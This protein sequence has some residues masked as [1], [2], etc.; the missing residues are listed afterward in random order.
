M[1]IN[2][3][4]TNL[5]LTCGFLLLLSCTSVNRLPDT[6]DVEIEPAS[7]PEPVFQ[8]EDL[9]ELFS[10]DED[11]NPKKR[12]F[13]ELIYPLVEAVNR[14]VLKERSEILAL[15]E[16]SRKKFDVADRT[17]LILWADKYRVVMSGRTHQ[18]VIEQLLLQ[19]DMVAPSLAIAQ[20]ANESGWGTSRF[21]IEANNYFGQWCFRKGCGLV[22]EAR[23][24]NGRHE[25]R[26]FKT[27]KDSVRSYIRNINSHYAYRSLW[28]IRR[29]L[30]QTEN[31]VDSLGAALSHG[32][33]RYSQRGQE[34]VEELQAM[35]RVNKLDRFDDRF[36]HQVS[37]I[38][39]GSVSLQSAK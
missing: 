27:P 19:V 2:H 26:K 21:A 7:T 4:K 10:D 25:V 22:P 35:I 11:I 37:G 6:S 39:Q 14:E 8:P 18:E 9:V 1:T 30:H 36:W 13:F 16:R 24:E 31:P 23:T 3:L 20:S 33:A 15:A 32:L 28:E 29:Q 5:I 12:Q 17:R 38:N 34:Y